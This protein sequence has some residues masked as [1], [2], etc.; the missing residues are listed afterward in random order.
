MRAIEAQLKI[1][2]AGLQQTRAASKRNTKQAQKLSKMVDKFPAA[3]RAIYA[4]KLGRVIDFLES[5]YT[6]GNIS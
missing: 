2:E 5:K 4:E 6:L 1:V 3:D